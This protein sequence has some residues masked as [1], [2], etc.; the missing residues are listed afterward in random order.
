MEQQRGLRQGLEP[1]G[2]E[3][4]A[5]G[6]AGRWCGTYSK[7][8]R[9]AWPEVPDSPSQAQRGHHS[10]ETHGSSSPVEGSCFRPGPGDLASP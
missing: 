5:H 1:V 3:A 7:S 4:A 6:K 10:P 8:R 9:S 2:R